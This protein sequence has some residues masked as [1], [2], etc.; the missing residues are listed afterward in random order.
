MYSLYG[1]MTVPKPLIPPP[2]PGVICRYSVQPCISL[3]HLCLR[4]INYFFLRLFVSIIYGPQEYK[5]C[6]MG[7]TMNAPGVL[8][9]SRWSVNGRVCMCECAC[10]CDGVSM[11]FVLQRLSVIQFELMSHSPRCL[12]FQFDVCHVSHFKWGKKNTNLFRVMFKYL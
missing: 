8:N 9:R 6:S 2:S 1:V 11:S 5:H 4:F 3:L 12:V 7:T 10:V